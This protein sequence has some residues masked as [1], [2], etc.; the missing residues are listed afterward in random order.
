MGYGG[1][2]LSCL[3]LISTYN[4]ALRRGLISGL[5]SPSYL[6]L[7]GRFSD[8][9]RTKK[10]VHFIE[11]QIGKHQKKLMRGRFSDSKRTK[12]RT[13]KYVHFIEKRIGKH[14]S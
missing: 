4:M 14:Q 8:S 12:K 3:L 7:R 10:Y 5:L 13:K 9:T 2:K 6:N 11:K 1:Y